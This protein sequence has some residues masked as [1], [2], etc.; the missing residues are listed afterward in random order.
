MT[1]AIDRQRIID[2]NLNGLGIEITGPFFKFSPA[3]DLSITP[4]PFDPLQ[5]KQLLESEGWTDSDGDGILDKEIN[6]KRV[7]F[8]FTL[9]YFVKN[10]TT[11]SISE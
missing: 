1:M 10:P 3:Y 7:K 2:Q 11:K 6:G 5:A 4:W 8:A 9:T